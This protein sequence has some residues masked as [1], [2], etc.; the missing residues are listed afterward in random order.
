MEKY[1]VLIPA[2][3]FNMFCRFAALGMVCWPPEECPGLAGRFRRL[4]IIFIL[5]FIHTGPAIGGE[6]EES[7]SEI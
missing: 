5:L 3:V 6:K 4:D 7:G 2:F 1:G